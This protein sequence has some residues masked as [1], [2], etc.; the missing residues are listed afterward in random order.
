MNISSLAILSRTDRGEDQLLYMR[1]FKSNEEGNDN[2]IDIDLDLFR[3]VIMGEDEMESSRDANAD[4]NTNTDTNT[5][6]CSIRH[7]FLLQSALQKMNQEIKFDNQLRTTFKEQFTGVDY[8]WIGLICPIDEYHVYGYITNTN[9]K[10][11]IAVE[12]DIF[13]E[14]EE[15]HQIR[16]DEIKK[17][18]VSK[19]RL[20]MI[21]E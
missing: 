5:D 21:G 9:I 2:D 19:F 14:Q 17:M 6:D 4:A 15:L 1:E 18:L 10:I 8:M 11:I 20:G 13:P 3:S 7:Q 16:G 12:D